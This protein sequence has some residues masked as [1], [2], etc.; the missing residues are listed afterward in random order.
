MATCKE[1]LHVDVCYARKVFGGISDN[2][3]SVCKSFLATVSAIPTVKTWYEGGHYPVDYSF[4]CSVCG[5]EI[6]YTTQPLDDYIY[7]SRCGTKVD[8]DNASKEHGF[9][10]PNETPFERKEKK[11]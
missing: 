10:I 2:A 5:M 1:C 8:W 6:C 7:C 11:E 9:G 3:D 4:R